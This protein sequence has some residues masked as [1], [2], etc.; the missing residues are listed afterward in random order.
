MAPPCAGG[1]TRLI[2]GTV[3]FVTSPRFISGPQASRIASTRA[4]TSASPSSSAGVSCPVSPKSD[5]ARH[6]TGMPLSMQVTSMP[7]TTSTTFPVGSS[8][9]QE[10]PATSRKSMRMGACGA[11]HAVDARV[12]RRSGPGRPGVWTCAVARVWVLT[13]VDAHRRHRRRPAATSP[14]SIA[15][16]PTPASMLPQFCLSLTSAR[17]GQ[18]CR[19]R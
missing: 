16:G 13:H 19:N 3:L 5:A 1:D 4:F 12:A 10:E 9:P 7:S 8:A 14:C 2:F 18:T 11:G 15:N 6:T 17:S